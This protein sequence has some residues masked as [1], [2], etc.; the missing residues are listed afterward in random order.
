MSPTA[1]LPEALDAFP[2]DMSLPLSEDGTVSREIWKDYLRATG[3][4]TDL[5]RMDAAEA[6]RRRKAAK[7]RTEET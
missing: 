2:N 1:W 6:K 5:A 4:L 3:Q 7:Y